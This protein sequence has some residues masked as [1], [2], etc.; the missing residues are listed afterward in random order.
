MSFGIPVRNGL[1]IGLLPSTAISTL[2]IGGRPALMLNFIGTTALDS[3]ITFSRG[4]N[5]TLVNSTGKITYAPANLLLRSEEFDNAYWE[6]TT[7]GTGIAPVVT[8]NAATAPDGTMTADQVVFASVGTGTGDRSRLST[9]L[10]GLA[11]GRYTVSFWVKA[12]SPSQ[13]NLSLFIQS[14]VNSLVVVPTTEWVRYTYTSTET[15][16]RPELRL[17]GNVGTLGTYYIWGAQLEQVT[18]QTTAGPY[19]ATTSARYYGP[20]F[21]YDPVTLA[22]KG[23]LIEEQR[24]NLLLYSEQFD[25]AAWVK[26]A[27]T[28]TANATTAPDGTSAADKLIATATTAGHMVRQSVT[29]TVA[30]YTY[31]V[32]AKAA[33]YSKLMLA[34]V[35]SGTWSATFDLATGTTISTAGAAVLSSKIQAAGS[36]WYRCSVTFT[37]V[38]ALTA[39]GVMGYP[40]T[41]ATITLFG[42]TYTGDGTSG[43]FAYGAQVELGSFATSYIPTVASTVTRSADVAT[44]TGTNFSSWYNA[45][46]GTIV[47]E[48]SGIPVAGR[49]IYSVDNGTAG[50]RILA[51]SQT[52]AT[53]TLFRVV[54]TTD[55]VAIVQATGGA[56]GAIVKIASAYKINDFATSNNGAAVGTDT[57]GTVPTG[58]NTLRIGQNVSGVAQL[59]GYIRQIAY[60]NTRLANTTLQ[61]LTV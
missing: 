3:R 53:D 39:H 2:R 55:Q 13:P 23:L 61:V 10:L 25:N 46:E 29:P 51:Q 20:R 38:A 43:V 42:V 47:A 11:S 50:A 41:G 40:N 36:G 19:V 28:V 27:A 14:G 49:S 52:A 33:E 44:M 59:C 45:S 9:A 56:A 16:Q 22:P 54:D 8:A 48:I 32:Y 18:Y 31:S 60:Y 15:N 12:A 6:K 21:D 37:G 24:V 4:S 5:A 17:T 35:G 58:L 26:D 30:S 57:S 1:G 34:D 7:Q